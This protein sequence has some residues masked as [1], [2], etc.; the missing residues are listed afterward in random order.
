MMTTWR[1]GV[2]LTQ[3]QCSLVLP[4]LVLLIIGPHTAPCWRRSS[5]MS[6]WSYLYASRNAASLR[7]CTSAPCWMRSRTT[8]AWPPADAFRHGASPPSCTSAPCWRRTCTTSAWPFVDAHRNAIAWPPTYTMP[9][10][11]RVGIAGVDE[12]AKRPSKGALLD[13]GIPRSGIPR[14]VALVCGPRG[15]KL[16]DSR[17][18]MMRCS[19]SVAARTPATVS[20][21][22]SG[23]SACFGM[24]SSSASRDTSPWTS[25]AVA[26]SASPAS[27][28]PAR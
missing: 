8:A 21:E 10:A 17:L 20:G 15:H 23:G 7:A 13:D 19:R 4:L 22:G 24:P 9:A 3:E 2:Q 5:T 26:S 1:Q 6:S 25:T 14:H 12:R 18:A 27:P 11:H 16:L 28:L